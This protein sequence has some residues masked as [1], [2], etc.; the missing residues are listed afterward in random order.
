MFDFACYNVVALRLVCK[1]NTFYRPVV[2]LATGTRKINFVYVFCIK[3]FCNALSKL[4]KCLFG[5]YGI[6]ALRTSFLRLVVAL[7]SMY[8]EFIKIISCIKVE[9]L[10]NCSNIFY[11]I[12]PTLSIG[13]VD[14]LSFILYKI[15]VCFTSLLYLIFQ[16]YLLLYFLF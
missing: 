2:S 5:I 6:I 12:F 7:L 13:F 15:Y 16:F 9:H 1:C 3:T 4:I 8:T 14:F 10:N 11:F